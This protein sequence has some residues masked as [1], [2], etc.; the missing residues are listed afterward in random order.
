MRQ[1]NRETKENQTKK[2]KMLLIFNKVGKGC[3]LD[4]SREVITEVVKNS[5]KG[6]FITEGYFLFF[7]ITQKRF[8]KSSVVKGI[9]SIILFQSFIDL[10]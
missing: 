6:T 10:T 7:L 1:T 8:M 2:D 4:K 5:Y 9:L 3:V